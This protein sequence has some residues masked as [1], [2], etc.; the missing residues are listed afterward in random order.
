MGV[1]HIEPMVSVIVATYNQERTIGRTLDS[2]LA[3]KTQFSFEIIIG[4]DASPDDSTRAICEDY[5]SRWPGVVRLMPAAPNKGLLTNYRDCLAQSRGRYVASCAG[6][7]WWHNENKIELQVGFLEEN[8]DYVLSYSGAVIDNIDSG[9]IREVRVVKLAWDA[10]I[11]LRLIKSNFVI[12]PTVCFRRD[13]LSKID[14]EEFVKREYMA[15][16]Y[17]M[18]LTMS[19]C[20]RFHALDCATVTYTQAVGSA[21]NFDSLDRQIKFSSNILQMQRDVVRKFGL[22]DKYSEEY[23]VD[24]FHRSIYNR[25]RN[26]GQYR[27]ARNHTQQIKHK[28]VSDRAKILVQTIRLMFDKKSK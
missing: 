21:S 3:Q 22:E 11:F 15:E 13:V 17:P 8:P 4:E 10:D 20:G 18:W 16:D 5:A 9:R 1:E 25:A 12:A 27:I 26:L 2:I 24:G 19:L 6:D 14:F 28:K 7:D 23:L